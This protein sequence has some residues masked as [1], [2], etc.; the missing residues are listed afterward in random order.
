V[1]KLTDQIKLRYFLFEEMQIEKRLDKL[2]KSKTK[3]SQTK[4]KVTVF[5]YY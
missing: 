4:V 3:D 1:T 2:K 5:I